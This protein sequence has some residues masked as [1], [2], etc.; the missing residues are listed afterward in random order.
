MSRISRDLW[1]EKNNKGITSKNLVCG[2]S[3]NK[4]DVNENLARHTKELFYVARN[5]AREQK[6]KFRWVKGGKIF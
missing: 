6:Y 2:G 1:L 4:I 5:F 3:D